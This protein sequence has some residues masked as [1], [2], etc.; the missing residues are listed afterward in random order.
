MQNITWCMN[1][2][3]VFSFQNEYYCHPDS[4]DFNCVI[5]KYN[6]FSKLSILQFLSKANLFFFFKK[7]LK[8]DFSQRCRIQ[9]SKQ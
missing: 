5:M 4:I 8:G 6:L 7:K 1:M 2:L 3:D 9:L